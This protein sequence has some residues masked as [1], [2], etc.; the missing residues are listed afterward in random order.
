MKRAKKQNGRDWSATD[1]KRRRERRCRVCRKS[2][3]DL[4]RA[5]RTLELAHTV[6]REFDE[7]VQG[8]GR[9]VHADAVVVLCGP[10]VNTGTCHNLF[11]SHQLDLYPHMTDA[12]RAWAVARV[13]EGDAMRR[14]RGRAWLDTGDAATEG[15]HHQGH[16]AASPHTPA[17]EPT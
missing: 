7:R 13:G 16:P 8:G 12:E 9:R 17:Q 4:R 14:L 15:S 1:S 2:E 11:D 10:A 6:G 3:T 5:G